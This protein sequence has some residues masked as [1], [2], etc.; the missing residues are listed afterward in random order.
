MLTLAA[1][2]G[3]LISK[4]KLPSILGWLIVGMIFGSH[5]V[6]LLPQSVLDAAWYQTVI[7]YL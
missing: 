7:M 1:L 4:V 5:A 6:G 2:A 3:R